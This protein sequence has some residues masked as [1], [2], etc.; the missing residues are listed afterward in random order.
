MIDFRPYKIGANIPDQ[1][2]VPEGAEMTLYETLFILEKDGQQKTFTVENYPYDDTTWVF[3][4]S[5]TKVIKEGYVPP[6]QSFALMLPGLG[7]NLVDEIVGKTGAVFFM[8]SPELNKIPESSIITLAE[9]AQNAKEHGHEFY[10]V[11]ASGIKEMNAFNQKNK[12]LFTFL[13][14]DETVLKTI[15]RSNPGLM[16]LYNGTITAKWHYR[17]LPDVSIMNRPLA[18]TINQINKHQSNILIWLNLFVLIL[19]PTI[20]FNRNPLNVKK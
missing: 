20:I 8:I 14:S 17:N 13:Q 9:L 12:T 6:M 4:D 19:I 7:D 15:I 16:M 10:C 1:M 2:K 11:T 3:I 5:E 18:Y